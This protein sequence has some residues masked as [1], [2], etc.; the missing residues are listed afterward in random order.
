MVGSIGINVGK[1]L[2]V[3]RFLIS[4]NMRWRWILL[5]IL[6]SKERRGNNQSSWLE[7]I[8]L[9]LAARSSFLPGCSFHCEHFMENTMNH[10]FGYRFV[11]IFDMLLTNVLS[12]TVILFISSK[13]WL[14]LTKRGKFG[15][16]LWKFELQSTRIFNFWA[17]WFYFILWLKN[18]N[19]WLLSV[20]T[21]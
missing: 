16:V 15:G 18:L 17:F 8:S 10:S 9:V 4:R 20:L 21:W 1:V 11:W 14:F 5:K 13:I 7:Q 12:T 2:V 6:V 3:V 19:F